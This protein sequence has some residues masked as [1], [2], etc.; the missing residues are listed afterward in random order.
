MAQ[1]VILK[2]SLARLNISELGDIVCVHNDDIELTGIG[3][4]GFFVL[5]IPVLS[6]EDVNNI[7]D[8]IMPGQ[9]EVDGVFYY[10][11]KK[12][13][14]PIEDINIKYPGN[15]SNITESDVDNINDSTWTREQILSFIENRVV[16][17]IQK[18]IDRL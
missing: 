10:Q 18:A 17:K 4:E 13:L 9:T 7:I 12:D 8:I 6:V 16:S 2:E 15:F 5:K 14:I 1:I 11:G 3:Y